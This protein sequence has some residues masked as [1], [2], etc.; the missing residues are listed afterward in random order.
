MNRR[1]FLWR[2]VQAGVAATVMPMIP[3]WARGGSSPK[4]ARGVAFPETAR[5][6]RVMGTLIEVRVPDLPAGD[7]IAAIRRVRGCVEELEA[8]MTVFR[9][10]SPLVALNSRA[11]GA[12]LEVP[13]DLADAVDG[14]L[15]ARDATDGAFDPSVGPALKAWGLYDLRG[16][17]ATAEFL[18]RWTSRPGADA[19]EVDLGN[20]RLRRLDRRVELDLGGIGKG[21]AVDAALGILRCA[22]SRAA[23]VNLGGEIGVLGPPDDLPEGWPVGIAHPRNP[24]KLCAEFFLRSGHV[25]T[26]GDYERWVETTSGRKHHIL[27]PVTAEPAPRVASVTVWRRS[28]READIA[29]TASFVQ[30][31]RGAALSSPT[32]VI[33]NREG[34]MIREGSLS[35]VTGCMQIPS[36][37]R[38]ME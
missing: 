30:A 15:R 8:A 18:R 4:A 29:S 7:A 19:I 35:T 2:M 6:W 31:S 27:D 16:T 5:A 3:R 38:K 32:F 34:E 9:P 11:E 10:E 14:A 17:E 36:K 24:G 22:G 12:W 21:I 28:G 13:G 23:L 37:E 33:R 20:A 26:S 25:A 1:R